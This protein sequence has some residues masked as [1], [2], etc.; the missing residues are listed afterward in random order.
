MLYS[1]TRHMLYSNPRHMLYSNPR[2]MLY[3]NPSHMLYSNPRHMLYSKS[4]LTISTKNPSWRGTATIFLPSISAASHRPECQIQQS[5]PART[6][7]EWPSPSPQEQSSWQWQIF[8]ITAEPLVV[9]VVYPLLGPGSGRVRWCYVCVS[10]E[11]GVCESLCRWQALVSVYRAWR[12][13]ELLRCIQCSILL[14]IM[15]ICFLTCICL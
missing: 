9:V 8:F 6:F 7:E 1:N 15:D 4:S 13:P 10:C 5:S 11:S 12:I 3:S 14:H 2:Y